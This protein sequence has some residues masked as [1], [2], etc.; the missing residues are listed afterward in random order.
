MEKEK[1]EMEMQ[2]CDN[3]GQEIYYSDSGR[4][5]IHKSTHERHCSPNRATPADCSQV[6][7]NMC[8]MCVAYGWCKKK[9]KK[10]KE[11]K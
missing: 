10:E 2:I 3:C 8:Q 9:E 1:M 5:W 4:C 6:T 11:R 7:V